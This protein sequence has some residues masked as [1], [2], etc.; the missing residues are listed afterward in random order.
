M[1]ITQTIAKNTVFSF[2]ATATDT[3]AMIVVGI[4][5]ARYLGTEQYGMYS[6]L[7]QFLSLTLFIV[8]LGMGEMVK[9]FIAEAIGK[10][11]INAVNGFARLTLT[12]RASAGLLASI[13]ILVIANLMAN[14]YGVPGSKIYF[15]LVGACFLP[16]MLI[17]TL[18]GIF[19]GYQKYEY[20]A[21]L[22][23]IVSPL[24]AI[25]SIVMAILGYGIMQL[26]IAY[27]GIYVLGAIV[28]FILVNRLSPLR[29]LLTHSSL[30]SATRN[31][32]LK[33]SLAA[34][35]MLGVDYFLWQQ[36]EVMLLGIYRPVQEVGFYTLAQKIPTMA[37]KIIP[38]VFGATLL[39]A[40]AEQFGKGNMDK[41]R[42]IYRNA[43]RYLMILSLPL[44]AAGIALARP[45]N[46]L[47]YGPEYAPAIVLTQLVFVPF[48]L[49]GLTHAVSSVIYGIRQPTL[50]LKIGAILIAINLGLNFW[51]IP[52]YGAYGAVI[53][54]SAP[55]MLSLPIYIYFVSKKIKERWP[56]VDTLKIVTA[57]LIMGVVTFLIQSYCSNILSLILGIP[58]GVIIYIGALLALG[59]IGPQDLK[60]LKQIETRVPSI[61]KRQYSTIVSLVAVFVR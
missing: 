61:L 24:R 56:L 8:N 20:G 32:A 2:I 43:A 38:F 11:N 37:I 60:F 44:A 49:W 48:A 5:L 59:V 34:M 51:L 42:A 27:A 19:A 41:I 4:V 50:L 3:I 39:P 47:L 45:I 22:T 13:V 1:S 12:V 40:I 10:N 6:L 7:M 30:D 35:G 54:T 57:S 17:P 46:E 52:K 26:L 18:E 23:L 36:P 33:Y 15:M 9:R 25:I 53:A 28:G 55:R 16:Y 21:F 14:L 29:T 31:S 58:A